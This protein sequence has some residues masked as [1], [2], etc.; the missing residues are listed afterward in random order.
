MWD[1]FLERWL[2]EGH[3]RLI[4]ISGELGW[5]NTQCYVDLVACAG[6]SSNIFL[7]S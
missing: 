7:M 5:R 4:F 3:V 1:A 6:F 2:I